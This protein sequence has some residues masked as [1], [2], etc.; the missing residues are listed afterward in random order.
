MKKLFRPL[1]IL[2]LLFVVSANA[3]AV[4]PQLRVPPKA[5]TPGSGTG[6]SVQHNGLITTQFYKVTVSYTNI[7][8]AGVTHDLTIA[9][10]P[11]KTIV[12]SIIVDI[13]QTFVCASVCTTGT[14]SAT[15]GSTAGGTQYLASFD[16]DAVAAAVGDDSAE[17]GSGFSATGLFN[18]G[19]IA[20][21]ASGSSIIVRFTSGTGNFGNG[22]ATNLNAGSITFYIVASVLP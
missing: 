8:T 9:T 17:A 16:I 6:V 2:L 3:W 4:P 19:Y 12:H 22:T 20:N 5:L 1:S 10:L 21:W 15:V 7:V 14:L 11:V 13:T 18:S